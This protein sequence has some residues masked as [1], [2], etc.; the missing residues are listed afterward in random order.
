V[1]YLDVK[2]KITACDTSGADKL[3]SRFVY[4]DLLVF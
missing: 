3:Q 1:C 2:L 4:H